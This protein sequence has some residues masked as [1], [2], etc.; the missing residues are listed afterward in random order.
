[1]GVTGA[2]G[3][4]LVLVQ[5]LVTG[6]ASERRVKREFLAHGRVERAL[7]ER[8]QALALASE[9]SSRL[10]QALVQV[11]RQ[12]AVKALF[13][14]TMS[15]E[16]RT[17]LHGIL[18]LNELVQRRTTDPTVTHHL[19]LIQASGTHL[20]ELIGALLDVSRIDAGRLELHPA[21]FDLGVEVRNMSDLYEVRCD[22]KGISFQADVALGTTCWVKADAPRIRQ[23]LH[24]LLGNAVKF[25]DRGTVRFSA[26]MSSGTFCF[27]VNDTGPGIAS[28]DLP[29]IF[30]AFRQAGGNAAKPADGTGLGLTIARELA[31]AME[32][33]IVASSSLG[34]GSR[35]RFTA[36]LESVPFPRRLR[37]RRRR[38]LFSRENA[39]DVL[40]VEDNDV[41]ALI[42]Q[43]HL[44]AFGARTTRVHN[45]REAVQAATA[46]A[47]PDI[48]LMDCRMPIMDGLAATRAIR[49]WE[50]ASSAHRLPII[51][52]TAT[53]S[54]E[55][56]AE[57]LACGMDGFLSK[58][59]TKGQLFDAIKAR[60]QTR[61]S[62]RAIARGEIRIY[63]FAASLDRLRRFHHP[64]DGALN[65]AL[66]YPGA[67]DRP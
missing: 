43:A 61:K 17:P 22:A 35:F 3:A 59:F 37:R 31:L 23:I 63:K 51:A 39:C 52:L 19:S 67:A 29:H 2:G 57:C 11:Q 47:R 16:L 10:E 25:T 20:L 26:S 58:P 1:M 21:P 12:S 8:S 24:N 53:P 65:V 7:G 50:E 27:E 14:A 9:S 38:E 45:G 64:H 56:R 60:V 42:V 6:Y 54:A 34:L 18:G 5:T 55:D 28:D 46:S 44:E 13:L 33:D 40:L 66:K 15:H 30:E 48:V 49:A 4:V 32:G 36:H 41:N 62:T